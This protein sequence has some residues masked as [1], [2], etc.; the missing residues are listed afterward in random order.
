MLARWPRGR[1][2]G[3]LV[4]PILVAGGLA[5]L[6]SSGASESA[7]G[8]WR[9]VRSPNPGGSSRAN[10]LYGAAALSSRDAWAVGF[11]FK[12]AAQRS[13]I[14]HWNR[15]AWH[16]V[17]S[18]SPP[19]AALYGVAATSPGSAWAVGGYAGGTLVVHWNGTAWKRVASPNPRSRSGSL[20]GVAVRSAR[21]AWA[22]GYYHNRAAAAN[23]TLVLHWNGTTWAR[24]ASP[25]PQFSLN[26]ELYGVA[27]TSQA[28]AWAVGY[29]YNGRRGAYLTLVLHWNGTAWK[30]VASPNVPRSGENYLG[31]VAATSAT[32]A[33]AVGEY[34]IR[35][36]TADRTLILRW[37]GTAWK[38][39]ASPNPGT[40]D[41]FLRSVVAISP[42]NAWAVGEY[43][44]FITRVRFSPHR[45]LVVHWNGTTWKQMP[46]P[47]PGG[48]ANDISLEGV[49]ATSARNVWAVGDSTAHGLPYRTLTLHC[50]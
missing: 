26:A 13:L 50:G 19:H 5:A 23:Q 48:A 21:D 18:P 3:I 12:V 15:T 29:Y 2:L 27:A 4:A 16:R 24:L 37:D 31:A 39:M 25:N 6:A 20:Q 35:G 40:A 22:V 11:S 9:A 38:R 45:T 30:R 46:S 10:F 49:A 34:Y 8:T 17:A 32:N 28:N 43:N 1:S 41:N 47:N 7:C 14:L 42:T 36:G 44:D 33:W